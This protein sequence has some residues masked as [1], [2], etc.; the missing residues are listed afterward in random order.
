VE[1]FRIVGA[2]PRP[3]VL[4][5][6]A[7]DREREAERIERRS[8]R[9]TPPVETRAR[10]TTCGYACLNDAGTRCL[11]CGNGP[12]RVETRATSGSPAHRTDKQRALDRERAERARYAGHVEHSQHIG[13]ILSVRW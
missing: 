10:C 9:W 13:R 7:A 6:I 11:Y 4:A 2:G 5:A 3:D 1:S 12:V 8:A